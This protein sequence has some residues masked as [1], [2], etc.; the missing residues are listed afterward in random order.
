MGLAID[1]LSAGSADWGDSGAALWLPVNVL[2]AGGNGGGGLDLTIRDL[3]DRGDWVC[4]C[5]SLN[6]SVRDLGDAAG[7]LW[8]TVS[9]LADRGD[10]SG[11]SDLTVWD[12]RL[13]TGGGGGNRCW[14]G[15]AW[16]R[17]AAANHYNM[18]WGALPGIVVVVEIVKVATE[19]LVPSGIG[20]KCELAILA[21]GETSG[22]NGTSLGWV[23]ELELVVGSDIA[24]A[25]LRILQDTTGE[26]QLEGS[27]LSLL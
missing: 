20:P 8:L 10:N 11:A 18:N 17:G 14:A 5:R 2:G 4:R 24:S 9:D 26:S 6:L 19:A 3:S 16:G 25:A 15:G 22:V 12:L 21:D 1:D 7:R 27:G 13:N 23:I